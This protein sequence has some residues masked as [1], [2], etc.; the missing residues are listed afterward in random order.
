[1]TL[2]MCQAFVISVW[3]GGGQQKHTT[4]KKRE[5]AAVLLLSNGEWHGNFAY[6]MMNLSVRWSAYW[7]KEM[8]LF[9]RCVCQHR[10]SQAINAA[11]R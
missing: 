9:V 3:F 6:L 5:I 10:I 2:Y 8:C 4:I 7:T 1:M 11:Q